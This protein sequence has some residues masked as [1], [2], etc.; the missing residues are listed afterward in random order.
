MK[1][2]TMVRR[3]LLLAAI[4][5]PVIAHAQAPCRCADVNDLIN[6]INATH[7][8]IDKYQ[9]DSAAAA[10]GG[11]GT[12][13]IDPAAPGGKGNNRD[14]L[15]KSVND[16]M[17]ELQRV[18]RRG[19]GGDTSGVTCTPVVKADS[20]CMEAVLEVHEAVHAR[21]CTSDKARRKLGANDDRLAGMLL[22]QRLFGSSCPSLA[23]SACRESSST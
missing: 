1:R 18:G 5:L 6:R 2:L 10:S 22:P 9:A 17:G 4:A 23:Q 12:N 7:A 20:A 21:A 15:Q 16:A 8:A 11:M 13:K 19:G 14:L 3:T